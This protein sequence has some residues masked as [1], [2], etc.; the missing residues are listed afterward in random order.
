MSILI[1]NLVNTHHKPYHGLC[2]VRELLTID[3]ITILHIIQDTS[4]L[5]P[6]P[7]MIP[8]R[9]LVRLT[10]LFLVTVLTGRDL[11]FI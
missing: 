3:L 8:S 7:T 11:I 10:D 6:I 5:G 9:F 4:Y 2:I 1:V